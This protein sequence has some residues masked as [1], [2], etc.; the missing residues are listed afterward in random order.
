[1]ALKE[2][3]LI[4]SSANMCGHARLCIESDSCNAVI[5]FNKSQNAPWRLRVL[6]VQI[7]QLKGLTIQCKDPQNSP[8]QAMTRLRDVGSGEESDHAK[9]RLKK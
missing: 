1:M 4:F 9:R 7:E 3:L 6:L 5:C 8:N 2:V